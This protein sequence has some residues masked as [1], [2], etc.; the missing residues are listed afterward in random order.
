AF[1]QHKVLGEESSFLKGDNFSDIS[2]ETPLWVIDPLD[3]TT[4]YVHRF[5]IF[6][7]SIGLWYKGK[8]YAG[9]IDVP[10]LKDTYE[11]IRCGG[12]KKNGSKIEVSDRDQL[13]HALLAT[14]FFTENRPVLMEQ[15]RIFS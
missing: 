2:Q 13:S 8:V 12:A 1:P 5:P 15:L 10:V 9:V 6:C 4:N 3:G 7:I 14:G 11:A